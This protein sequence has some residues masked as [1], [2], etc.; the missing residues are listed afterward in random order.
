M[1]GRPTRVHRMDKFREV[2]EMKKTQSV[3]MVE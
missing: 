2:R 3:E 1:D